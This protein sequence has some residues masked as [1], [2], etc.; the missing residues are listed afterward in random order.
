L[1]G[2]LRS[3]VIILTQ[4]QSDDA[5]GSDEEAGHRS[6][7]VFLPSHVDGYNPAEGRNRLA[8]PSPPADRKSPRA[9]DKGLRI[10]FLMARCQQALQKI[11]ES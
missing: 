6:Q 2:Q 3:A 1:S 9:N 5:A 4:D 8:P 11:P 7:R 10:T